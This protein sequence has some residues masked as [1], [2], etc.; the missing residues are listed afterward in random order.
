VKGDYSFSSK[1]F[2]NKN[3]YTLYG[4]IGYSGISKDKSDIEESYSLDGINSTTR[5]NQLLENKTKARNGYIQFSADDPKAAVAV[6]DNIQLDRIHSYIVK[7]PKEAILL[8]DTTITLLQDI[9]LTYN[10]DTYRHFGYKTITPDSC[11]ALSKIGKVRL[12]PDFPEG[13]EPFAYA[14]DDAYKDSVSLYKGK[15]ETGELIGKYE[16]DL[17]NDLSCVSGNVTAT[18]EPNEMYALVLPEGLVPIGG[19]GTIQIGIG[20]VKLNSVYKS[21]PTIVHYFGANTALNGKWSVS[22]NDQ[23]SKLGIVS[24]MTDGTATAY[25]GAKMVLYNGEDSIAAAPLT[26]NGTLCYA[27]FNGLDLEQ[28]GDY[29]LVIPD[30]A[31]VNMPKTT[32][33][34]KGVAKPAE[35]ATVSYKAGNT[36]IVADSVLVGSKVAFNVIEADTLALDSLTLNGTAVE[37]TDSAY[38]IDSIA[39]N[40]D[41]AAAIRYIPT[42]AEYIDVTYKSVGTTLETKNVLKGTQLTFNVAECDTLKLDSLV[43][44]GVNV[45]DSIKGGAFTTDSLTENAVIEAN[46]QYIPTPAPETKYYAVDYEVKSVV[47]G[48]ESVISSTSTTMA[49]DSVFTFQAPALDDNWTVAVS[50][51]ELADDVYSVAVTNDTTVTVTCTFNGE[52]TYV[53]EVTT[54]VFSVNGKDLKISTTT[55]KVVVDGASK[56][57]TITLYALNGA[58][59][60]QWT[61]EQ[62][63]Q[64]ISVN[65]GVYLVVVK[66]ADGNKT[67]KVSVK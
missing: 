59:L 24:F 3:T 31:I 58:K 17:D 42:P 61:V 23:L 44:N 11:S 43:L 50:A 51:G 2:A 35:Y 30:S 25:D 14:G 6:F 53:D 38:A 40:A 13:S 45:T 55:G 66:G 29:S 15:D 27:D 33:K 39:A 5:F 20:T 47:G 4:G 8:K 7:V 28:D 54:G 56:G 22:D 9:S 37:L 26:A 16:F 46:M 1:F 62:S 65:T 48:E 21:A 63:R 36:T 18:L 60:G 52:V 64:T 32:Q 49:E 10:G 19:N 57:D 67:A 41:L 34:F 12:I